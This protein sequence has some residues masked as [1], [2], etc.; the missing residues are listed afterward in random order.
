MCL[1]GDTA[2]A[3]CGPAQGYDPAREAFVEKLYDKFSFLGDLDPDKVAEVVEHCFDLGYR[4]EELAWAGEGDLYELFP[5]LGA[6]RLSQVRPF[7][8]DCLLA[9]QA[10]KAEIDQENAMYASLEAEE[11]E[12]D[13]YWAD[14]ANHDHHYT[15]AEVDWLCQE[16]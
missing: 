6:H 7:A 11:A 13:K 3:S 10:Q 1:C 9:G 14:P 16:R 2:C 15:E 5:V 4:G 8:T 12:A